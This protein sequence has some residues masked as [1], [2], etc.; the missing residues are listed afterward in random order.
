MLVLRH[1]ISDFSHAAIFQAGPLTL[2]Q[3]LHLYL[4]TSCSVVHARHV[5]TQQPWANIY[6]TG[7]MRKAEYM[8]MHSAVVLQLLFTSWNPHSI[9]VQIN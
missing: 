7:S 2:A 3:A 9:Q 4:Q 8:D 5:L 6:T 1:L